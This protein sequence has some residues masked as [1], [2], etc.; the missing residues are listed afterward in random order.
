MG[1][2][3]HRVTLLEGT[4]AAETPACSCMMGV[5]TCSCP[6]VQM[7]KLV[8]RQQSHLPTVS[9]LAPVDRSR[10]RQ[11]AHSQLVPSAPVV[12]PMNQ[13]SLE[14]VPLCG[15]HLCPR[16]TCGLT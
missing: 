3:Q 8:L 15:P 16:H 9:Q 13:A 12:A 5:C 10:S 14:F 1:S 7:T 6:S 11:P 2:W 4:K